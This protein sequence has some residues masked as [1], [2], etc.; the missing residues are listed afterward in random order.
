[1][2][3]DFLGRDLAVGGKEQAEEM[4]LT[5]LD[6]W[7]VISIRDSG[8]TEASFPNAKR[9]LH[10][11]VDDVEGEHMEEFGFRIIKAEDWAA[12]FSF[13]DETH[14]GG[15]LVHCGLGVSRSTAVATVILMRALR[16]DG[17]AA[18]KA[19]G[20]LMAIRPQACPNRLILRLGLRNWMGPGE[21]EV[22]SAAILDDP[23]VKMN[24]VG[25]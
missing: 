16:G 12:I 20:A 24:L 23:R 4:L 21:A 2:L 22:A 3:V 6:F 18:R 10:L 17:D 13:V 15:L 11:A 7:H 14:P 19:A 25:S 8:E 1:M 9:V 5:D